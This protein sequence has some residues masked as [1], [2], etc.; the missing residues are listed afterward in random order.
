MN[1]F[2]QLTA[3]VGISA[4]GAGG[5]YL[6][7]GPPVRTLV[8]DPARL[9]P[10]EVC[11]SQVTE[12]VLWIDARLRREWEMDGLPGSLLW[13][14]DP[15][16]DL[17]IFEA[18]VAERLLETPRVVVYCGDE[19]CGIS[20]QVADRIRALGLAEEVKVL[21]GG[22]RTLSEAGRIKGSN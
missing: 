19:S 7:K 5:T 9:K 18:T 10:D 22:W 15:K 3:V 12:P 17:A 4:L 2:L 21:H 1:S 20:R 11:L 8:C 16:E 6:I 14:T 13:N